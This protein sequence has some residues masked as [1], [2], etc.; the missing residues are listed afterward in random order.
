MTSAVPRPDQVRSYSGIILGLLLAIN[1]LNYVDRMVLAAVESEIEKALLPGS[2][3]GATAKMGEL[4]FAFLMSY[5]IAAPFFGWLADRINRWWIIAGGVIVW[6]LASGASGLASSFNML[7]MTRLFVGIGEAAYGPAAPTLLADLYSIERRGRILSYFY[8]AIPVGS[9]L[10]YMLG[11]VMVQRFGWRWAFYVSLPPGLLLGVACLFFAEARS[12]DSTAPGRKRAPKQTSADY[13]RL[14]RTPSY[15]LNTLAMAAMTFALGAVSYF[16]PRYVCFKGK[17]LKVPPTLEDVNLT[18]GAI[19]VVTG[20]T[21]TLAGIWLGDK[22]RSRFPGSYFLV[23]GIGM[24]I[25]MPLFLLVIVTPFVDGVP[26]IFWPLIFVIE[27]CLFLSTGPANTALANVTRP[28]IRSS[29]FAINIFLI[30][31]LGDAISPKLV[32]EITDR[33]QGNMNVGFAA[34][35]AAIGLSGLFWIA[36]AQFL[37]RDT[38]AASAAGAELA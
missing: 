12:H 20:I 36:G 30:H 5:M 22:L 2:P 27:F 21:A 34:V 4:P 29:A 10:G 25:A 15:V 24:L 23:S 11:G 16:M 14:A 7:L 33:S 6:S 31:L 13:W 19:T 28:A 8:L 26:A 35:S 32:G 38:D 37:K 18:F 1:L 3:A 17:D 9:A